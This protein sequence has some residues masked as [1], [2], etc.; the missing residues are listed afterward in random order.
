MS[1]VYLARDAKLDRTVAV[2]LLSHDLALNPER[3]QRFHAEARAASSI[4]HPHIL[5]V[6]DFG[7]LDGRPF[8]VTEFVEGE[9]VRQR[10]SR[11]PMPPVDAIDVAL[12]VGAALSAAH[13][14][15]LVHRDIKPEN[16]MRRPDGYVKV[17]DFGLAKLT[18]HV[19][20]DGG[21]RDD[22]R[23]CDGN[24]TI[25][26]ARAGAWSGA[27]RAQRYLEPWRAPV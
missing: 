6:H 9:T 4:N 3:L 5:V 10:L 14:R 22:P 16:V 19:T 21:I 23:A 24:A 8:I 15:G 11:G 13:A 27:R 7:N 26:V 12:Q 17:L 2:K 25:H 18:A 1:E 20:G